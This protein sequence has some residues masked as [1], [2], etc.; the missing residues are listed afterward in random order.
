MRIEIVLAPYHLGQEN[1]KQGRGPVRLLEAGI[2]VALRSDGH[3]VYS[4]MVRRGGRQVEELA[5]IEE[6]DRRVAAA[7][8]GAL[9]K[10]SFPFVLA[11]DCNSCIGTLGGLGSGSL[12]VIWFDAHGDFNTP[13]TSPSGFF[14]GMAISVI[15]GAC[16]TDLWERV[17]G[18]PP[19]PE[20][21]VVLAGVRDLDPAEEE[22]LL[23]SS[24]RTVRG[25][26]IRSEGIEAALDP[27]LDLLSERAR[28]AY[29][30][31]DMDALD[32][33][34]VE[35]NA[36]RA[37]GGLRLEEMLDAIRHVGERFRI[38]AAALT[39]YDPDFDRRNAG[40]G[41]GIAVARAIAAA[42]TAGPAG[43]PG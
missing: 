28:D 6:V 20:S 8:H 42:A 15:T 36:Y 14:D 23:G 43:Q 5:A 26:A 19:I 10:G 31:V 3:E 41:V 13:D 2:D 30:H 25:G 12:V 37:P 4:R 9:E 35:P 33:A 22:R 38:R 11:G 40:T 24:L 16:H 39:A 32:P 21:N 18:R 7:V 34:V 1:E 17:A 27:V 29:V